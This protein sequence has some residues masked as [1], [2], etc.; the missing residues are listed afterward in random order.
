MICGKIGFPYNLEGDIEGAGGG[1]SEHC[2]NA[3]KLTNITPRQQS[4][5]NT[6][7]ATRIF[8]SMICS[9][10]LKTILLLLLHQQFSTQKN[11]SQ[12]F[13][14]RIYMSILVMPVNQFSFSSCSCC[15][16]LGSGQRKQRGASREGL[17]P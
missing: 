5:R 14:V 17:Y 1:G 4:H 11:T 13:S 6:V 16:K 15:A 2:N 10:T 12:R 7:T 3:K 8:S 9:S